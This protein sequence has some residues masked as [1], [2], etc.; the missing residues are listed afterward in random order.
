MKGLVTG[1]VAA[2][3]VQRDWEISHFVLFAT[4]SSEPLTSNAYVLWVCMCLKTHKSA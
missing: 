4:T 1:V 3:T 2:D